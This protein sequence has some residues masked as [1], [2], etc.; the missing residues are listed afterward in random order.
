MNIYKYNEHK[1][2]TEHFKTQKKGKKRK[3][4]VTP[5]SAKAGN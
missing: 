2:Y 3:Q 4:T 1:Q 5:G